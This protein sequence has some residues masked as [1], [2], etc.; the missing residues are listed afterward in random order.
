MQVSSTLADTIRPSAAAAF[1]LLGR[2]TQ[3]VPLPSLAGQSAT[4]TGGGTLTPEMIRTILLEMGWGASATDVALAQALARTGLA[5]TAESLG[6]ANAALARAPGATP[7]AYTLAKSMALPTTPE[8]LMALT[9]ALSAP[10]HGLPLGKALPEHVWEGL[11]WRW[12]RGQGRRFCRGICASACWKPGAA[13]SIAWRPRCDRASRRV[14]WR[15]GGQ[16]CSAWPKGL[17]SRPFEQRRIF[18][19]AIGKGSNYSIRQ[20]F[21]SCRQSGHAS[22]SGGSSCFRRSVCPHGNASVGSQ[23]PGG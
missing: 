5:L 22:V 13:P 3:A 17:G 9:A 12:T 7:E 18:W 20:R 8:A 4:R 10:V 6:E 14:A 11:G 2:L 21:G 15:T 19:P 1:A 16:S 23:P